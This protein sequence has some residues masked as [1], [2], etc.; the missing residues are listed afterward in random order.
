MLT[1]DLSIP[2][3]K[4]LITGGQIAYRKVQQD[5]NWASRCQL[6]VNDRS[7][8]LKRGSR[9]VVPDDEKLRSLLI[10]E[11]H[12]SMYAGHFGMAQTWAAVGRLFLW[13][14]LDKDVTK[15][16]FTC[17][18]CQRNKARRHKALRT[19][20]TVTCSGEALACGDLRFYYQAS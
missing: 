13:E 16:V 10:S 3:L 4:R 2:I 1:F 15:F 17:V 11:F 8:V 19:A 5:A 14:S 6:S 7:L 12:D 9:I 18:T 20:T